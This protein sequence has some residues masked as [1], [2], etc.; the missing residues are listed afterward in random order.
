MKPKVAFFDFASCE[1]CQLQVVNLEEEILDAVGA[2]DIVSFREAMKEHSDT[3]DIAFIEGSIIRP[4]DEERLKKIRENA[5]TLIALGDCA[6]NGGVNK[7]S[8]GYSRDELVAEVY[9]KDMRIN[10]LFETEGARAVDEVVDV[11]FHIYGCPVRKETVLYYIRRLV[12]GIL[13]ERETPP[14]EAPDRK[15]VP[16]KR[17]VVQYDADKCILCRRCDDICNEALGIHALGPVY[18]GP[19]T[20]IGTPENIGFDNNGCI[21]CGQCIYFCPV[22]A[23]RCDSISDVMRE[24]IEKAVVAIDPVAI[25]SFVEH[26]PVLSQMGFEEVEKR[27]I[28]ALRRMGFDKVVDYTHYLEESLKRDLAKGKGMLSWCKGAF[29]YMDNMGVEMDETNSPWALYSRDFAGYK[30]ALITPCTA[31]KQSGIDIVIS[32]PDLEELLSA[33]DI[34]LDLLTPGEYDGPASTPGIHPGISLPADIST[35]IRSIRISP[36]TQ[37]PSERLFELYPCLQ[38]CLSGGGNYSMRDIKRTEYLKEV[39][40]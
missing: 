21:R 32:A 37:L 25:A 31:M 11:D 27:V 19:K 26:D 33:K 20:E 7:L 4:M 8:A 30:K 16:D 22:G 2:V 15:R 10:P 5:K 28:S 38:R 17:S 14:F 3:Y 40:R 39:L 34:R 24:G 29:N 9:G 35:S 6:C 36:H 13:S 23:L 1:G 18:R 12:S